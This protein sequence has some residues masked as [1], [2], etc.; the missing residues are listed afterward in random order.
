[1]NKPL[2][3]TLPLLAAALFALASAAQAQILPAPNAEGVSTGHT[4]LAVPDAAK[5]REIWKSFGAVEHTSGRLQLLGFPGMYILLAEREPTAPSGE[6]TANHIAFSVQ[7]YAVIKEKLEAAGATYVVDNAETGQIL[8]DL[9]DGVRVEFLVIADQAEP[10]VFHH[11]HLAAMDQAGLRDWYIEVFGAEVG[12]R[13]GMPSA[14]IPGGRV[15]VLA[16]R[17]GNPKPTQ[18]AAIDHIGF[19]VADMAAFAAKMARMGIPFSRGPERVDAINLTIA[20]I[21]DPVGTYIEITEGLDDA[22]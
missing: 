22:E 14:V 7:N 3:I 8:A 13:N 12:E 18:G 11:T 15:D 2:Q 6:T 9:P 21:T 4:H 5:H 19:E 10:I 1:M 16:A 20:F 17:D